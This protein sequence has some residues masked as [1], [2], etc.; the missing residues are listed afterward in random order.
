MS[1]IFRKEK[2]NSLEKWMK[3][4][5][6]ANFLTNFLTWKKIRKDLL[7]S[8][9]ETK[10]I[11]YLFIIQNLSIIQKFCDQLIRTEHYL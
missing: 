6:R 7:F 5:K 9:A 1:Q 8:R 3:M 10:F 4:N 11:H 2:L